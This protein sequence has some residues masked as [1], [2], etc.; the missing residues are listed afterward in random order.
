M[1][2]TDPPP[3]DSQ[4][5][6]SILI[7]ARNEEAVILNCLRAITQLNSSVGIEV[8]I[9]NDQSTDQTGPLIADFITDKPD[10]RL[11]TIAGNQGGLT[12]KANVLAQLA[13]QARGQYLFFTDADTQVPPNWLIDMSRVFNNSTGIVTGITLPNGPQLFHKLQTIDW[14]YNLTLTHLVSSLGIPVTAMGNNMAVSRTAYEDVG[15]YESLPFSVVE[16]YALFQAIAQKGYGFRNLLDENVLAQ[17]KPVDTLRDFLHQR[18]R[19]MRGATALPPWMVLSLYAQYLVGPLLLIL[20]TFSPSLAVGLYIIRLFVQTM[21]LSFGL[22]RL[23]KTNLWPYALL[24]EP[25]QLLIGPLSVLFYW[26]SKGIEWKGRR[27]E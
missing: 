21:V 10:F 11:L 23:R 20:A 7:A 3:S 9:G 27:Y 18:K 22:S 26:F 14:L 13:Q 2:A 8:L 6:I 4:P 25:Y 12:G 16:D 15:G 5:F 17:T 1:P 24:F 19:W